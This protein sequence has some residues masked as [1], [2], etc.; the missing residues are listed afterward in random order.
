MP[1]LRVFRPTSGWLVSIL[2]LLIAFVPASLLRAAEE[3]DPA[4]QSLPTATQQQGF[5][6]PAPPADLVIMNRR[7]CTLRAT[8]FGVTPEQ[9]VEAIK[10]RG[11]EIVAQGGALKI[12]SRPIAGGVLIEVDAKPL[13]AIFDEDVAGQT[14]ET[15]ESV[16]KSVKA[17]LRTVVQ[18]MRESRDIKALMPAIG[19]SLAATLLLGIA[20][21]L[22]KR[23]YGWVA[24]RLSAFSMKRLGKLAPDWSE[25]VVGRHE[26]IGLARLPVTLLAWIVGLLIVYQW[27]AFVLKQFPYTRPWGEALLQNLLN[28]IAEFG[29]E[30]LGAVPGLLFVAL[31]FVIARTI[32]RITNRFFSQVQAGRVQMNWLDET[33]ARPTGKLLVAIIW[34][35]AFVAAYPYIPGSGS[36]AFKGLGVFVG[37]MLSIGSS[38][39]V[40]QAVSGLMLMYTR[41]L[42][43][44][45]FVQVGDTEG[46]VK[47]IGFL[48]TRIETIRREEISIPNALIASNVTRNFSRLASDTGLLVSTKVT[49]GYDTPWRQ[50][51]AML[52]MAAE[53]TPGVEP[54][55]PPRVLQTALQDFYVEYTLLVSLHD[56]SRRAQLLNDLHANIQDV[57]NDYG[58]QITS[59]HYEGDPDQ[60]KIVAAQAR[61]QAP[62]SAPDGKETA[63]A[64]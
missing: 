11:R 9:R 62:A 2:L 37:L 7:I 5:A 58:V 34:L 26:L 23:A 39:I 35:F 25:Q 38:G 55:P 32:V 52:A 61:Y 57:F 6:Y 21:W 29:S 45:E 54:E 30:I 3:P 10:A 40:N 50:V 33:T 64:E 36:E 1:R 24:G 60:P 13:L 22:L 53:R 16:A 8:K 59:P 41:A 51:Q 20:V 18:E 63:Q 15:A 47:A 4:L 56:P 27:L 42:R 48:T 49:I 19:W 12:T 31:I 46:V 43:P 28:A 17:S 44:G 14:G